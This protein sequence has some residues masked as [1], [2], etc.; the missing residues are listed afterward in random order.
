MVKIKIAIYIIKNSNK[1]LRSL[2][3]E[4]AINS[5]LTLKYTFKPLDLKNILKKKM[6]IKEREFYLLLHYWDF[7]SA[8]NT[9]NKIRE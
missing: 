9:K 1:N 8:G 5:E 4:K 2:R 6:V 3:W 7:M